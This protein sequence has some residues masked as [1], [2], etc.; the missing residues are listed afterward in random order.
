[1]GIGVTIHYATLE[2]LYLDPRN[3]RLGRGVT[4]GEPLVQKDVLDL[5]KDWALDELA[6]S[7]VESGGFWVQEALIVVRE[8]LYGDGEHLVVIEGN[9]RLAALKLLKA[10]ADGQSVSRKWTRLASEGEIPDRLFDEIPYLLADSRDDVAAFLGFRHVTGIKQ[11][12][13]EEKAEYI[14][15]LVNQGRSYEDV[16]RLIGSNTPTVRM[17][18]IAF[19]ILRQIETTV[20]GFPEDEADRRFSVMYLSLRA[21]GVQRYLGIDVT[22]DPI[23]AQTPVPDERLERLN[24]FSKWVFGTHDDPPLFTDSRQVDNFGRILQS[25]DGVAYLESVQR[26]RLEQ[27]LQLSGGEEQGVIED[28]TQALRSIDVAL[29]AAH[30]YTGSSKVVQVVDRLRQSFKQLDRAFS[31]D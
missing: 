7:F 20:E 27:A 8:E 11:W 1:M 17:S 23:A 16:M 22:A 25:D 29:M 13:P 19:N 3:P 14:A 30:R 12:R 9:R 4:G 2:A 26:P 21:P 5:M 15:K 10:A 6:V 24:H 18:Y 28:L 31:D